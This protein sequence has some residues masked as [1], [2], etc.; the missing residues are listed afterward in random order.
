MQPQHEW[1]P[2]PTA[3][4]HFVARH[5]EL[6]YR[7]GKW[8]FHNFLR[9]FRQTLID[10]DAIRLARRRFWVAHRARFFEVGF[11]C[12]TGAGDDDPP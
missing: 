9:Y 2:G 10:R 1:L 12:A 4:D 7:P 5:P 11:D 8:A 3:W 6:G